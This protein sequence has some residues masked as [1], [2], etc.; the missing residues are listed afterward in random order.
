MVIRDK[1]GNILATLLDRTSGILHQ[2]WSNLDLRGADLSGVELQGLIV[3]NCNLQGADFTKADLYWSH[4]MD[5]NCEDCC[6]TGTDLSGAFF[7]NASSRN[8]NFQE[9]RLSFDKI[10]GSTNLEGLISLLPC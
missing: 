3:D 9:A 2:S 4:L 10:G 8:A 7:Y 6:F 1:R 5:V